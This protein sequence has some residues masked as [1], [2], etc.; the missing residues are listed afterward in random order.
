MLRALLPLLLVALLAGHAHAES[1]AEAD[2]FCRRM[3]RNQAIFELMLQA[4]TAQALAKPGAM[5]CTWTFA[6]VDGPELDVALDSTLLRSQTAA[7][8]TVLLARLPERNRGKTIEP[9]INVGD[10]GIYRATVED[11]VTRLLELEAV[12]GRRHVLMTVRPRG[13]AGVPYFRVRASIAFLAAGL[14]AAE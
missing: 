14:R 5:R 3:G 11:G 8:Q 4:T 6:Q 2:D 10:D 1:Q 12:K 9:L 7:R 13:G